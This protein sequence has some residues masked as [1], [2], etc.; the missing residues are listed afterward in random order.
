MPRK[1]SHTVVEPSRSL[2]I[3]TVTV[4]CARTPSRTRPISRHLAPLEK[5]A[6]EGSYTRYLVTS[7]LTYVQ[8][9]TINMMTGRWTQQTP[10]GPRATTVPSR[11]WRSFTV[12]DISLAEPVLPTA[13]CRTATRPAR[14]PPCLRPSVTASSLALFGLDGLFDLLLPPPARA[15]SAPSPSFSPLPPE[16]TAGAGTGGGN[17]GI[18]CGNRDEAEVSVLRN[19][20]SSPLGEVRRAT[21]F[22]L[23]A[24]PF[25]EDP[26]SWRGPAFHSPK[27]QR[28]ES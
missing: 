3:C 10:A 5:G 23:H 22:F 11:P 18:I 28:E 27:I 14:L 8:Y 4:L 20:T 13:H 16:Q 2:G 26:S 21:V 9:I 19:A 12:A 6:G 24:R 1:S 7:V 15:P 25:A 17:V